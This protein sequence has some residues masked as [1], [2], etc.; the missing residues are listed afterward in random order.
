MGTGGEESGVRRSGGPSLQAV[1]AIERRKDM[2]MLRLG[3]Y[4]IRDVDLI[5]NVLSE[6]VGRIGDDA[7]LLRLRSSR[8][9]TV[10][11]KITTVRAH[12]PFIQCDAG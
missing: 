12:S 10:H 4:R 5:C 7:K 8:S 6:Y 11:P 9:S 2:A 1:V 3:G